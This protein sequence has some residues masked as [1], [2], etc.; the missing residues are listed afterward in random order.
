M[1]GKSEQLKCPFD[2]RSHH[3]N[4]KSSL[5]IVLLALVDADYKLFCLWMQDAM[6]E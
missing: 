4:Y 6:A 5:S 1:D 2:S 3:F